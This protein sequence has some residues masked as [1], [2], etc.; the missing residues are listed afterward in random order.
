MKKSTPLTSKEVSA[1]NTRIVEQVSLKTKNAALL[2][3]L[4]RLQIVLDESL[5]LSESDDLKF[6]YQKLVQNTLLDIEAI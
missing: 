6:K 4:G 3:I 2:E 5:Q 1:L